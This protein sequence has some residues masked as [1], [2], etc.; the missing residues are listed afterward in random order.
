ML[1]SDE[2]IKAE[3]DTDDF[4][5]MWADDLRE[6]LYRIRDEYEAQIPSIAIRETIKELMADYIRS[7]R[8]K[9]MVAINRVGAWLANL[10]KEN[11][12]DQG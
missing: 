5:E 1:W 7:Y 3:V 4:E 9:D 2:R 12:N 6:L 11:E 8:Y 10:P